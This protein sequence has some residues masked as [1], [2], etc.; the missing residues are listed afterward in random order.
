MKP[1]AAR[2]ILAS[3]TL[4]VTGLAPQIAV[5]QTI[6]FN[7]FFPPQHY[8]CRVMLRDWSKQIE[9]A[10]AGRV[11]FSV[12]PRSLA[13][14][15]D[16]YDAVVNGVMDAAIQFNQFISNRVTGIQVGQLPFIGTESAESGSVATW[17]TYQ[18]FFAD[19][20]EY[21]PVK[22]LAAYAANG[23]EFYSMNDQPI[24]TIEDIKTRK[25]WALP[26]VSANIIKS[27][28]S[29]VVAGPA[30]Q[31]L[32]IISKGVVEGYAGIPFAAAVQFKV[33]GYTKSATVF[34][35]KFFTPTFSLFISEKKWATIAAADRDAIVA[36]SGEE[37]SRYFGQ[38]QDGVQ[39]S[40]RAQ[41]QKSGL[42]IIEGD[43]AT[44]DALEVL[45]RPSTDAWLAKVA[46]MGVDGNAVIAYYKSVLA[47]ENVKRK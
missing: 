18:K 23:A 32:E 47:E 2:L 37:I 46:A 12:P 45:G 39:R 16:Q 20:N 22:L 11:K 30:V 42:N 33:I 36:L 19:K 4:A 24:R 9:K 40:A 41:I 38:V 28:G 27:T 5:A 1:T 21:G 31:M 6:L 25:M 10:T 44:Q 35:R 8:S 14:P 13:A 43:A 7:C 34:E 3:A 29:A 17:R 15:P 26:G